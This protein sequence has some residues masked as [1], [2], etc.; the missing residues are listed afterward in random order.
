MR[1]DYLRDGPSE[2]VEYLREFSRRT[3]ARALLSFLGTAAGILLCA[4]ML[5]EMHVREAHAEFLQAQARLDRSATQA[6]V[7]RTEMAQLRRAVALERR[8]E[9]I[10]DTSTVAAR[11]MTLLANRLPEEAWLTS[12]TWS[13]RGFDLD[14]RG[15]GIRSV[16]KALRAYSGTRLMA[17]RAPTDTASR[18]L[19][20]RLHLP[21]Q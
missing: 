3:D 10:R 19:D 2:A 9:G 14:G 5:E 6:G 17:V 20:F 16:A 18:I 12:L 15:V 21:A 11:R 8:L 7:V 4:W 13:E 1:F